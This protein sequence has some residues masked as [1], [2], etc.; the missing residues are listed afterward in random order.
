MQPDGE[1]AGG[2]W[3]QVSDANYTQVIPNDG[4]T[5][6]QAPGS[7]CLFIKLPP[8]LYHI[9]SQKVVNPFEGLYIYGGA[10]VDVVL[11]ESIKVDVILNE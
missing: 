2:A 9:R 6:V 10:D 1:A 4:T 11:G 7:G 5:G 3:I 8:G